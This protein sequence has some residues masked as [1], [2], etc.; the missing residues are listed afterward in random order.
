MA[1]IGCFVPVE[2]ASFR[3]ADRIYSRIGSDDD[4]ETNS[5]TFM[6]EV[7]I[8]PSYCSDLYNA[9]RESSNWVGLS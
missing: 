1:Q 3:L 8:D 7:N 9:T 2:Y 6:V 5:S 4:I